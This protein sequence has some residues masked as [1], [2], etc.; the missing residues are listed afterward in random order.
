MV[1]EVSETGLLVHG[2][3]IDDLNHPVHIGIHVKPGGRIRH[4]HRQE[5][6]MPQVAEAERNG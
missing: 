3:V 5:M 6:W 1:T 4:G 2:R